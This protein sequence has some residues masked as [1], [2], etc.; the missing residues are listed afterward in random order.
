MR[1]GAGSTAP[2]GLG[3]GLR[4]TG[5][6]AR[7]QP[8]REKLAFAEVHQPVTA[9]QLSRGKA[10]ATLLFEIALLMQDLGRLAADI[11]LFYTQEFG[12]LELPDGSP[13]APRS[14]RRSATRMCSS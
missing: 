13:P 8:T 3:R 1:P 12:F 14:C 11:L 2:A 6:A 5:I 7:P 9:V 4:H 10:E